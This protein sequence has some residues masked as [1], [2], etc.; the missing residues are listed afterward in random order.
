MYLYVGS[1]QYVIII[2]IIIIII[3]FYM[4]F[5]NYSITFY[6]ILCIFVY[7]FVFLF[8]ILCIMCFCIILCT[9]SRFVLSLSCFF[10]QVYTGH[11]HRL[12]TQLQ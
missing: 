6:N 1:V 7:C 2:I 8:Y 10:V 5:S 3:C 4:L 11:C 12:E 9:V